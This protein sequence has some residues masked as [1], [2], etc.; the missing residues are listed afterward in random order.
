MIIIFAADLGEQDTQMRRGFSRL[1][2]AELSLQPDKCEFLATEVEYL[3]HV[4]SAGDINRDPKK[5]VA[6]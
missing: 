6:V 2:D 4:I 3:G 1:L 5:A